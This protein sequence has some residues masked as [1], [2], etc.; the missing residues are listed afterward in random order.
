[1]T[2]YDEYKPILEKQASIFG[3]VGTRRNV[4]FYRD[5][6]EVYFGKTL[7]MLITHDNICSMKYRVDGAE[8]RLKE[9]LYMFLSSMYYPNQLVIS[10]L[11]PVRAE[12]SVAFMY[13]RTSKLI[14]SIAVQMSLDEVELL[15]EQFWGEIEIKK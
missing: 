12:F 13:R 1:M 3:G 14:S 8:G 10:V 15:N 2:E 9:F 11:E 7:D 4:K 6:I 5:R